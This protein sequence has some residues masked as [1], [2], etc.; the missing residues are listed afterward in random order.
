MFERL[1]R[2]IHL[3]HL[4]ASLGVLAIQAIPAW[5][6]SVCGGNPDSELVKGAE[7]GVLTMV[8]ITYGLLLGLG[9]MMVACFVR[10]RRLRRDTENSNTSGE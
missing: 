4:A 8:V 9:A 6:C 2:M 5:A 1:G 3:R 7:A 10:S